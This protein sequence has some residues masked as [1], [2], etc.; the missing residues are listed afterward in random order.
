TTTGVTLP[1]NGGGCTAYPPSNALSSHAKSSPLAPSGGTCTGDPTKN[2][3]AVGR[4]GGAVCTVPPACEEQFCGGDVPGGFESCIQAPGAQA[5]PTGWSTPVLVGDDFSFDC[6][7]C[8][9]DVNGASTCTNATLDIF[10]NSNCNQNQ[11]L[12]TMSIDGT[13]AADSAQGDNPSAFEYHATLAQACNASG[14]KTASNVQLSNE[15]T[16]CCK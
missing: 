7:A 4:N 6:S 2:R 3:T 11:L 14:A 12:V 13:C 5:C 16:I 1:V 10:G 8:T 15:R 9:C